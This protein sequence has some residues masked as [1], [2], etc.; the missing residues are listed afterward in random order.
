[1]GVR[2]TEASE[3]LVGGFVKGDLMQLTRR[4]APKYIAGPVWIHVLAVELLGCTMSQNLG[5]P[6]VIW[7]VLK[8]PPVS[9]IVSSVAG[10]QGL[11]HVDEDRAAVALANEELVGFV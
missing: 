10:V 1:M 9:S 7:A 8:T 6:S 11:K 3:T 2:N 4:I 5:Q